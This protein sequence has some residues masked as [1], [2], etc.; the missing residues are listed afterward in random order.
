M[1]KE[2]AT[3]LRGSA[4]E[5]SPH[6]L[7]CRRCLISGLIVLAIAIGIVVLLVVYFINIATDNVIQKAIAVVVLLI[8]VLLML[9]LSRRKTQPSTVAVDSKRAIVTR[10]TD[11]GRILRDF[12]SAS[13]SK[14]DTAAYRS[15]QDQLK[16]LA[17][18]IV[19]EIVHS[20]SLTQQ[21]DY[22]ARWA[23]VYIASI[24]EHP[25]AISFLDDVVKQ[26]IPPEESTDIEHFSSVGQ[27]ISIRMRAIRG[28]AQI[29]K[30]GDEKAKRLLMDYLTLPS[31]SIRSFAAYTLLRLPDGECLKERISKALPT[32]EQF[33]LDLETRRVSKVA[34]IRKPPRFSASSK[35]HS[36]LANKPSHSIK[37]KERQ[38]GAVSKGAPLI[39]SRTKGD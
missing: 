33:V 26:P 39:K 18:D 19:E 30:L 15:I 13:Y 5:V 4:K 16:G 27:E 24:L 12:L 35:K 32:N 6:R 21:G 3:G 23:L 38:T 31:F 29:A 7:P 36:G 22:N 8:V 9:R 11:A 28:L 10:N 25:S 20:Y 37:E 2:E 14:S 17:K 34:M 1:T